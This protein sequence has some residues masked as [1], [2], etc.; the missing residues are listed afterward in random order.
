MDLFLL[1]DQFTSA[2]Y[3]IRKLNLSAK[4]QFKLDTGHLKYRLLNLN[5]ASSIIVIDLDAILK[6]C[7]TFAN[8]NTTTE[9]N[10]N[11]VET[12]YLFDICFRLLNEFKDLNELNNQGIFRYSLKKLK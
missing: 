5:A 9:S 2:K 1:N 7:I 3:L 11:N 8:E 6:E 12:S 4:L 10:N